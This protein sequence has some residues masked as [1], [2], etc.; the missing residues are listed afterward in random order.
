MD[1]SLA[2]R[3]VLGSAVVAMV[4]GCAPSKVSID[5]SPEIDKYL[6]K[7]IAIV[8]FDHVETP[9]ITVT[10]NPEFL[11]PGGA[12][13][14]DISMG[15]PEVTARLDHP[16][17][18]VPSYAA[19]KVTR[20]IYRRLQN[21]QGIQVMPLDEATAALKA[22]RDKREDATTTAELARRIAGRLKTDAVLLGRV[23]VYQERGGS[24]FGGD[25][26]TVGF[27]VRLVAA[28]G[29]TL[30]VGNYYEQ[31]RPMNEDLV[32]FFQRGGVFVTAEELAEYG[33]DR[34]VKE[35]PFGYPTSRPSS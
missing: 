13:R 9:Q 1:G 27:E 28:D 33:A 15:K 4:A 35:F 23:S 10:Q 31:Q 25:P 7:T 2:T 29:R 32:G 26:A 22:A 11:V 34:L 24:K 3:W 12:K 8:P 6:V 5:R 19:E 30:W 20:M 17:V 16:T 14:S 21:W 18:T